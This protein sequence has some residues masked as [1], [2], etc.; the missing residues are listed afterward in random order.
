MGTCVAI[1]AHNCST[2]VLCRTVDGMLQPGDVDN[3]DHMSG[4]FN[5][6]DAV[7]RTWTI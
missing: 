1:D 6:A 2:T 5:G 4:L 3:P 7:Q